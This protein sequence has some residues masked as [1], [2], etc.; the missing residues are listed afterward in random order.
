MTLITLPPRFSS[1]PRDEPDPLGARLSALAVALATMA[2]A[3]GAAILAGWLFGNLGQGGFDSLTVKTNAALCF[4]LVGF[5]IVLGAPLRHHR[6]RA[7]FARAAAG[8]AFLIAF[9]TTLENLLAIDLGIDQLLASQAPGAMGVTG[10]NRMGLPASLSHTLLSLGALLLSLRSGRGMAAMQALAVA[11][12]VIIL[13]PAVGYLV[14]VEPLYATPAA[15]AIALP[16]VVGLG[17]LSASLLC[18]RARHGPIALVLA[19]DPGGAILRRLA[20]AVILTMLGLGILEAVGQARGW[21][22][23]PMGNGLS[24]IG[25]VLCVTAALSYAARYVSHSAAAQREAGARLRTQTRELQELVGLLDLASV[26]V[27]DTQGRI[28]RWSTGCQLLYGYTAQQA[29]GQNAGELLKTRFPQPLDEL[30]ADL[31]RNGHWEGELA[32]VRADGSPVVVASQW[33]LHRDAVGK[34][35]AILEDVTDITARKEFEQA[36]RQSEERYREF[37]DLSA[38]GAAHLE[39]A[40]GRF[41]RVNDRYCEIVGYSRDELLRMAVLDL[42]HPDD[43]ADDEDLLRR[44]EDSQSP[45]F[46]AD[47]RYVRK[48]G[49]TIWI[50]MAARLIRDNLGR[51]LRT[52]GVVIDITARKSAEADLLLLNQSLERRVAERTAVAERRARQ[53]Q[54]LAGEISTAEHRERRRLARVLHDGLQQLLVAAKIQLGFLQDERLTP[55]AA[56]SIEQAISA[57]DESLSLSRSLTLDLSPPI[58]QTAGLVPALGWLARW[59]EEKHRLHVA[60]RIDAAPEPTDD[61]LRA[62]LFDAVRELLLNVSKYAQVGE[63]RIHV[64]Q[65]ADGQLRIDVIDEGSGFDPAKVEPQGRPISGLGL[66]S[67]RERLDLLGGRLTIESAPGRGTRVTIQVPLARAAG[68]DAVE[69]MGDMPPPRPKAALATSESTIRLLVADDHKI[70]REG[71]VGLV[72]RQPGIQVVAEAEDG[73]AALNL[74]RRLRPDVVLMDV[75]MPHMDGIE[76]TAMIV[77]DLPDTKVIGLSMHS[78][79]EIAARMREAGAVAYLSKDGPAR[80]VIHAI[81]AAAQTLRQG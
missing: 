73:R 29:Q 18:V 77:R 71:L 21:F 40:T 3:M 31:T 64:M 11:V 54:A 60:L 23:A 35:V 69:P 80:S 34:P 76:A 81:Q 57:V 20:P 68:A 48:D 17:L 66:F 53:L 26:I 28:V 32:Q 6:L 36:L 70:V 62:F 44:A 43:R 67:I 14:G 61:G 49:Q 27:R 1:A 8:L 19:D 42:I 56:R 9:A 74:A 13:T 46:V 55:M 2:C 79:A 12:L 25:S 37:F 50:H 45:E 58:L 78:D 72:S 52:L 41:L 16:S 38:I 7:A 4:M 65:T 63:A 59:M 24:M 30:L 5:A 39:P 51:P 10:P 15:T 75:N 33:V 47:R 22:S